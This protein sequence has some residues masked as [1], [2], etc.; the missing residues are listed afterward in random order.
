MISSAIRE[1][2]EQEP[3]KPFAIRSSSGRKYVVRNPDLAVMLKS[4]VWVATPNSD[5][6]SEIPYLYV[7]GIESVTNGHSKKPTRRSRKR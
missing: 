4:S 5:T 7:A 3:F 6:M 2:L 1:R